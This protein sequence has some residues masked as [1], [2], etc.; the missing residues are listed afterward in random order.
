MGV[1]YGDGLVEAELVRQG[2]H[3][4]RRRGR[5]QDGLGGVAGQDVHDGEHDDGRRDQRRRENRQPLQEV[6]EHRGRR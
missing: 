6:E 2:R 1:A 5:S 3:G 4:L